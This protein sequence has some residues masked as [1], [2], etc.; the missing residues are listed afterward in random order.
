MDKETAAETI[1]RLRA[2]VMRVHDV[3][4]S[5]SDPVFVTVTLHQLV[6]ED[7]ARRVES[8]MANVDERTASAMN[9]ALGEVRESAAATINKGAQAI[10][11]NARRAIAASV[12]GVTHAIEEA[13]AKLHGSVTQQLEAMAR[14]RAETEKLRKAA[15]TAAWIGLGA[16]VG[17]LALT[18]VLVL[19]FK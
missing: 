2:E 7:L 19:V 15:Q 4:L 17:V 16:L 8:A 10:A 9:Q 14:E 5:P 12:E 1:E 13:G 11:E 18:L 3:K 6:M